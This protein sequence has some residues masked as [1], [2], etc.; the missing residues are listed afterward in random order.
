[1]FSALE[2]KMCDAF[3]KVFVTRLFSE[4]TKK[5]NKK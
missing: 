1:M 2:T 4:N 5:E 3:C